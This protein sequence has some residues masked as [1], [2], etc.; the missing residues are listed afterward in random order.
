MATP[1]EPEPNEVPQLSHQYEADVDVAGID[2]SVDLYGGG[3]LMSTCRDIAT[4]FRALLRGDVFRKP[5][6]LATML[7]TSEGVPPSP[8]TALEDSPSDAGL[9]I[10][11]AELDGANWW[12]HDGYWGTAALTCPERDVTIVAGNQQAKMPKEF[13]RAGIVERASGLIG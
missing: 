7:T 13:R 9:Y 3:G 12:G 2:P 11:K 6:T 8:E 4:F 5:E 1:I 10:F